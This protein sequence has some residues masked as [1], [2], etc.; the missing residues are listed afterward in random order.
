MRTTA[1]PGIPGFLLLPGLLGLVLNYGTVSANVAGQ[2]FDF[3]G[4]FDPRGVQNDIYR[5]I[6][7]LQA[8]KAEADAARRREELADWVGVYHRVLTESQQDEPPPPN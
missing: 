1:S 5:R 3:E 2:V 7:A 6:E 4:V 8:R